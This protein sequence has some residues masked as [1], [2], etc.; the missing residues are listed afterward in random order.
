MLNR[1]AHVTSCLRAFVKNQLIRVIKFVSSNSMIQRTMSLVMDF[2][3]VPRG[4]HLNFHML[5]ESVLTRVLTQSGVH[6][7]RLQGRL[8]YQL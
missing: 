6:V 8:C 2:E 7:N 1:E 5:Y 3:N 4:H